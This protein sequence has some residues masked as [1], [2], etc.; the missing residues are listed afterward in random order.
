MAK[1]PPATSG[2][3]IKEIRKNTIIFENAPV[4]SRGKQL[5]AAQEQILIQLFQANNNDIADPAKHTKKFWI[6]LSRLISEKIGRPY[7]WQSCRR[8]V[9]RYHAGLEKEPGESGAQDNEVSLEDADKFTKSPA[10]ASC[11]TKIKYSRYHQRSRTRSLS[12][13]VLADED[14]KHRKRL[15]QSPGSSQPGDE[16]HLEASES[17]D[18]DSANIPL[19]PTPRK[20]MKRRMV[21]GLGL[22]RLDLTALNSDNHQKQQDERLD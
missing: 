7:S 11:N 10:S 14:Q 12:P 2:H 22:R 1:S 15:R 8:R 6:L 5:N 13:H 21:E 4:S 20:P 3:S 16:P 19:P 18:S 17:S 9:T